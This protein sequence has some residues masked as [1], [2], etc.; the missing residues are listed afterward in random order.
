MLSCQIS[1][2]VERSGPSLELQWWLLGALV[3]WEA[4]GGIVASQSPDYIQVGMLDTSPWAGVSQNG[5]M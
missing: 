2:P 3:L 5:M 4:S 1:D